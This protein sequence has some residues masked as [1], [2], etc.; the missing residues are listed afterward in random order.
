MKKNIRATSIVEAMIVLLIVTIAITWAYNMFSQAIKITDSN[1]NKL[2]AIAIAKEW[3]EA[4]TNIRD[5]NWKVLPWDYWNCWNTFNYNILCHNNTSLSTDISQW[6]YI[7]Y[8][9]SIDNRWKL[10]N[11]ITGTYLDLSY[12]NNFEVWQDDNNFYTQSWS[13]ITKKILPIFTREIKIDYLNDW[14]TW[15]SIDSNQQRMQVTSLVQ[16]TDQ[17]SDSIKKVELITTLTNW[18][19]KK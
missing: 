1:G 10:E 15:W 7:I 2:Q 13:L 4:M 6:S 16:W 19:N 8:N 12:R 17:S 9:D 3:I 11:K 14:Y 5:T 18:K